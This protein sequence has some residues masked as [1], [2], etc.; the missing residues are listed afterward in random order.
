[1]DILRSI[2]AGGLW[3][4][5]ETDPDLSETSDD[6]LMTGITL[7][8]KLLIKIRGTERDRHDHVCLTLLH[9]VNAVYCGGTTDETGL[10]ERQ[11]EGLANGLLEVLRD[12]PGSRTTCWPRTAGVKDGPGHMKATRPELAPAPDHYNDH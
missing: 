3:W 6:H 9:E 8:A 5:I 7:P 4:T 1:M 2:Q 12:N 10:E 11:I